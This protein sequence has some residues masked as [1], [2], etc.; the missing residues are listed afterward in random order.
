MEAAM[1]CWLYQMSYPLYTHELYRAEV[2]EGSLVMNWSIGEATRRPTQVSLGDTVV[3][4]Y[5]RTD[6]H[7][8]GIY[9]W[10][11]IASFDGEVIHF[12][13]A[14]PSDYLKM[15]PVP[16]EEVRGIIDSIRGQV[17]MGTM[18]EVDEEALARIRRKIAA[19]VYGISL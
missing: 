9:G 8:P 1:A 7:D 3:L 10:G 15:A 11:V 4:F 19:H 17:P 18:W 6:A 12:R 16:E 13:P 5:A 2:W 14:P